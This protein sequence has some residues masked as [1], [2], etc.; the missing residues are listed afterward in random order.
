MWFC[1]GTNNEILRKCPTDHSKYFGIGGTIL[2]T[3]LMATMSGGY[4]FYKAFENANVAIFFGLFW[5][6]MIFNLDRYIVNTIYT[7]GTVKITKGELLAG[8]PRIIIAIFLGIVISLPLELKLF[9][10]EIKMELEIMKN[11]KIM[12]LNTAVDSSF[13]DLIPLSNQRVNLRNEI[14]KKENEVRLL[15]EDYLKEGSVGADG[16]PNGKGPFYEIKKARHDKVET[17][18]YLIKTKYEK[19][20]EFI[21]SKIEVINSKM[22][23][24]GINPTDVNKAFNGLSASMEAFSNIKE[25]KFSMRIASF[26]IMMLLIIIEISPVLFKLMTESG[27]YD[28]MLKTIK[29]E[30]HV[31]EK[32]LISDLNDEINTNI[33][34]STEKNQNKLNA[35]IKAN[36]ELL[37]AIALAQ[38]EIAK[39]AVERWKKAELLK[40]KADPG[41]YIKSNQIEKNG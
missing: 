15:Y 19:E 9:E 28:D 37:I 25:D 16:R 30:V 12:E 21:D 10:D 39:T 11:E 22:A 4:A 13:S 14:S 41:C 1:A 7:D 20:I 23:T 31:R 32:Q 2:F 40:V 34:I 5:G 33:K 29:H 8:L 26:F 24:T 36:E 35:E 38:A 17:E 27:P 6:A 3:A 18:L